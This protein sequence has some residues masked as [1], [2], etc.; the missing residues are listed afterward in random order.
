MLFAMLPATVITVRQASER[1]ARLATTNELDH[2]RAA[3]TAELGTGGPRVGPDTAEQGANR[4]MAVLPP[5]LTFDWPVHGPVTSLF[6]ASH[7]LGI[8]IGVSGAP[9]LAAAGGRVV[10][11]GGR[12]CCEYGLYVD[13]EHPG[14]YLTR[15]GHLAAIAVVEGQSVDQGTL[16]GISGST[17]FSTGPHLHF[18]LRKD[19]DVQNPLRFLAGPVE[20]RTDD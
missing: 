15:Y 13:I 8:D 9:I 10:F 7:P 5:G 17:G 6:D 18:E 4:D 2:L 14:G 20:L 12:R 19:G 3:A 1:T 16:L 11:A